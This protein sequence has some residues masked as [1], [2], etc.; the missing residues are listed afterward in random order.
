MAHGSSGKKSG[1]QTLSAFDFYPFVWFL[2]YILLTL[3]LAGPLATIEA[4]AM[5]YAAGTFGGWL[6]FYLTPRLGTKT[7]YVFATAGA[8]LSL[9][10]AALAFHFKLVWLLILFAALVAFFHVIFINQ[11]MTTISAVYPPKERGTAAGWGYFWVKF[12]AVIALTW[13]PTWYSVIGLEGLLYSIGTWAL[14]TSIIGLLIGRNV[15][16]YAVEL[17]E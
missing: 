2:P 8:R 5:I 12:G 14:I 7:Q 1:V 3:K 11:G 10:F 6:T 13:A 9:I 15:Y 16:G 4:S 17:E